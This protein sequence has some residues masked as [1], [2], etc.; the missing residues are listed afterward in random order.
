MENGWYENIS[1]EDYHADPALSKTRM[2][3]LIEEPQPKP[4]DEALDF[5]E[6]FH[7][8]ILEPEEFD[9]RY[10]VMP[11]DCKPGSGAGMKARKE[12]F[13]AQAEVE[14]K[15]IVDPKNLDPFRRM[16]EAILT[17]PKVVELGLLQDGEV[18]K[19]GFFHDPEYNVATKVRLDYLNQITGSITDLKSTRACTQ[20]EFTKQAYKLHYDLQAAHNCYTT[21][22]ITG[23][24][25]DSFF[26]VAVNKKPSYDF[27]DKEIYGVMVYEADQEFLNSGLIKRAKA[28]TIYN[29]CLKSGQWPGFSKELEILSLPGYVL[30]KEDLRPVI[31]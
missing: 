9:R 26:F 17:H 7:A 1:N 12:A 19:T 15:K 20:R 25:H 16:R 22:R 5:G 23:V 29:E 4:S 6:M 21:T 10:I 24:T 8:S 13:L 11:D 14:G 27:N 30:R 28:L 3:K 18:E 2:S 31:E